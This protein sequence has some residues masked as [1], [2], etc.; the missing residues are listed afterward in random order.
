MYSKH[1]KLHQLIQSLSKSEKRYFKLNSN[2]N[3]RDKGKNY[4]K[5]FDLLE[6]MP[7]YDEHDL[8]N[9]LKKAGVSTQYLSADKNHLFQLILRSLRNFHTAKTSHLKVK[10]CLE[11]TEILVDKGLLEIASQQLQKAK[12][13]AIQHDLISYLPEILRMERKI[14]GG[15]LKVSEIDNLYTEYEDAIEKLQDFNELDF[16]FRRANLIRQ[17]LGKTRNPEELKKFDEVLKHPLLAEPKKFSFFAQ[18]R[19]HQIWAGYYYSKNDWKKEYQENN[20]LLELMSKKKEFLEEYPIEYASIFSRVLILSK[21]LSPTKYFE[22]LNQF[23]Q[24][25][26]QTKRHKRRVKSLVECLVYST[27]FVR[28]ITVGEFQKA[29]AIVPSFE[30]FLVDYKDLVEPAF[31]MNSYYKFAYVFI[32]MDDY[33]HALDYLN[34]VLNEFDEKLRPDVYR[35]SKI[36]SLVAHLELGNYTLLPYIAHSVQN[37]FKSRKKLFETEKL[38]ISFIKK[39]KQNATQPDKWKSQLPKLKLR[40][41]EIFKN[42][43]EKNALQYFDF[44]TWLDSR[45]EGRSFLE[46]KQRKMTGA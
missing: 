30:Q 27:E 40:F 22:T 12:K 33:S 17:T 1:Q 21:K 46:V 15:V 43:N 36:L 5:L 23:R 44:L 41:E 13:I 26:E 45:I 34:K 6:K 3:V 4:L 42:E 38:L 25:P 29:V 18:L 24:I 11:Y 8:E 28:M 14:N 16:L 10:E 2:Q 19:Y 31:V 35:Y 7:Q 9:N 37:H 20:L 32:G 39:V